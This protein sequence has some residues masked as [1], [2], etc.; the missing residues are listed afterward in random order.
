MEQIGFPTFLLPPSPRLE[1][2]SWQENP[3]PVES[4]IIPCQQDHTQNCCFSDIQ[5]QVW[6]TTHLRKQL[7][8]VTDSSRTLPKGTNEI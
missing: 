3:T 2:A 1:W 8:T 7:P 4:P 5:L 6:A